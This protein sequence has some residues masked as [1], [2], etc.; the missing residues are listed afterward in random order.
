MDKYLIGNRIRDARDE[1]KLTQEKLAEMVGLTPIA[2]SKIETGGCNPTFK[3]IIAIANIL[4]LSLDYL[5]SPKHTV[6]SKS[7]IEEINVKLNSLD[8][9]DLEY[10][11]DY[12][13]LWL[14]TQKKRRK[15]SGKTD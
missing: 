10:F 12:I 5:I 1:K 3:N 15:I 11:N 8:E 14:S 13:D 7:Y 4:G 9:L 2:I 6:K